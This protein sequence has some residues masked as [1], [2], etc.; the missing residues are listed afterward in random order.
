MKNCGLIKS[1]TTFESPV[2]W[3]ASAN[4]KNVTDIKEL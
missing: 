4:E 1:P 2:S 3:F